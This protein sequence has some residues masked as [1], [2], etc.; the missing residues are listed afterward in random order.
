M[1]LLGFLNEFRLYDFSRL[2]KIDF[3][4]VLFYILLIKISPQTVAQFFRGGFITKNFGVSIDVIVVLILS[5][6]IYRC[7]ICEEI[8]LWLPVIIII[9]YYVTQDWILR[10]FTWYQSSVEQI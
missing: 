2:V 4:I 6:F 3:W 5:I 1:I 7:N 10:K 9:N 8:H